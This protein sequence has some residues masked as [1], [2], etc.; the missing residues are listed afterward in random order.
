MTET[1][2]SEALRAVGIEVHFR[3][4]AER[5]MRDAPKRFERLLADAGFQIGWP[6]SS[7]ILALRHVTL[8]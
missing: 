4:L 3:M 8:P 1:L 5:G 6:D 7:H 2:R